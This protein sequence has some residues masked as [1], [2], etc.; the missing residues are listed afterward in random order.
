MKRLLPFAL[1]SSVAPALASSSSGDFLICASDDNTLRMTADL[2]S[3]PG[4]KTAVAVL[5]GKRI[6]LEEGT[7]GQPRRTFSFYPNKNT[8]LLVGTGRKAKPEITLAV[9]PNRS[10]YSLVFDRKEPV[11]YRVAKYSAK[12]SVGALGVSERDVACTE[13]HW[14]L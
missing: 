11:V 9:D 7:R 1:L 14:G 3:G 10:G 5:N 6:L 2:S 4:E 13:S 8:P 12:L